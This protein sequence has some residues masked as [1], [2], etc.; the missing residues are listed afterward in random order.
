[1]KYNLY[2]SLLLVCALLVIS[3][4]CK[5]ET[6][7][8]IEKKPQ[9]TLKIDKVIN[10][11]T[12]TLKWT[13]YEGND[14]K[15]Y[16]LYRSTIVLE[17][18]EFVSSNS[19]IKVMHDA[20]SVEFTERDMPFAKNIDYTI[21]VITDPASDENSY[22][23]ATYI[24]PRTL[25]SATF[26]DVLI[27]RDRKMIYLYDRPSGKISAVDYEK[28]VELASVDLNVPIGYCDLGD[29][30]GIN[31]EL[32][33]ST[34][35]GWIEILDAAT[36]TT[37]DRLYVSGEEALSVVAEKGKLFVSTTD[38]S[39]VPG[40]PNGPLKV[41]DRATKKL[42]GRSG[43]HERTRLLYLEGTDL[44]LIDI[45]INL[46][47][48]DITFFRFNSEGK[49]EVVKEDPYHGDYMIS[50]SL[51]K[52]FPDG[53]KFITSRSGSIF[54]K[55]LTFDRNIKDHSG[56]YV[57]FTFSENADIIYCAVNAKNKI[58]AIS[59]PSLAPLKTYSTSYPPL[60]I[61]RDGNILL[62]VSAG[63]LGFGG[64]KYYLIDKITL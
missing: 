27:N 49:A 11:S 59:Y 31:T 55:S 17:N 35:D 23:T 3:G 46:I 15:E 53:S 16:Q 30:G 6:I 12:I 50:P 43:L 45:T 54:N 39:E 28:S 24:R 47:P 63:I 44:E 21:V 62:S 7:F 29:F 36:L 56:N 1:M 10:D 8:I 25:L 41:Y 64:D 14:F 22:S 4:S 13:K 57:D 52:S 33:V 61:F 40:M 5:K 2:F 26:S 38:R 20:D 51:A 37:K 9:V 48:E 32:Y 60:R 58:E 18:N 42:I 34:Y 19:I